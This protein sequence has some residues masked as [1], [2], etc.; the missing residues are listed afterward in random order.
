MIS[1][2][3]IT[4]G[5]QSWKNQLGNYYISIVVRDSLIICELGINLAFQGCGEDQMRY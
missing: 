3:H 1:K 5:T 2:T 4:S